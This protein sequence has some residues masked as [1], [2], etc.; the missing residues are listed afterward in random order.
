MTRAA[1]SGCDHPSYPAYRE[2]HGEDPARVLYHMDP[3]PRIEVLESVALCRAY[4]DVETDR[5]EPRKAVVAATN[6][7]LQALQDAGAGDT[8][9]EVAS[10]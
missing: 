9:Q 6:A 3:R 5:D 2:R 4:L 8:D 7:R 1:A 10:A